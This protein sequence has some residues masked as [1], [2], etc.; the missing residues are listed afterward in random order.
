MLDTWALPIHLTS[1]A[2]CQLV[3]HCK[4]KNNCRCKEFQAQHLLQR[5]NGSCIVQDDAQHSTCA[6]GLSAL[7]RLLQSAGLNGP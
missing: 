4:V 1:E 7:T 3:V 6:S 2:F 5:C